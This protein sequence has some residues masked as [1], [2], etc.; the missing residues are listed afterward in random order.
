VLE[1]NAAWIDIGSSEIFV[2]MSPYRDENPV[3]V[4]AT[5][6]ESLQE[7]AACFYD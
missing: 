7:L 6:T 2:A 1:Q 5:F 3:L 4:F